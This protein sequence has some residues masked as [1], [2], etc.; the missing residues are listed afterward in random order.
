MSSDETEN[1][2]RLTMALEAIIALALDRGVM[3]SDIN[4]IIYPIMGGS[5]SP[6]LPLR[7]LLRVDDSG[8]EKGTM[9]ENTN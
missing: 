8:E 6:P 7:E 4:Q 5:H 3:S 1:V 2:Q 9:G